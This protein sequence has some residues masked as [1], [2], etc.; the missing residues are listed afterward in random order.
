M[1]FYLFYRYTVPPYALGFYQTSLRDPMFYQMYSKIIKYFLQYKEYLKPYSK[2]QLLWS[3]VKINDVHFDKL[4]TYFDFYDYDITNGIYWDTEEFKTMTPRY[5]VRQPRLNHKPFTFTFDVK[6]DVEGEAVF[7]VFLGPKYDSKGYPINIEDNWMNFYE[8]DWFTYKLKSG[9][10]KI[11]RQS[12]E[13]FHYKE[14]S[15]TYTDFYKYLEQKKVPF[16]MSE[17]SQYFPKRLMLPKGAEGGWPYQLF[18]FVYPYEAPSEEYKEF[19][20]IDSKPWGYPLDRPVYE[21]WWNQPNTYFED[22]YVYFEGEHFPYTMNNPFYV[23][24]KNFV[25]KN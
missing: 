3:G 8:L 14:D 25:P 5:K 18:V 24:G 17:K 23:Q 6:S 9:Q 15:V 1:H 7:K 11:E 13:F 4:V 2:N 12:K 20:L 16:D 22:V 21:A 19:G 10:N